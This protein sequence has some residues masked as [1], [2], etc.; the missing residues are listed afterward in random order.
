MENEEFRWTREAI[1]A[2]NNRQNEL[3]ARIA[4]HG[5]VMRKIVAE[6][7]MEDPALLDLFFKDITGWVGGPLPAGAIEDEHAF[8]HRV[9]VATY[10]SVFEKSVRELVRLG[11]ALDPSQA[12]R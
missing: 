5:F 1:E 6:G 11:P 2:L 12:T 10:L 7:L 9:R 4:A 8:E 3:D